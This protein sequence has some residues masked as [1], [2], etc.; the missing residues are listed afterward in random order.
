MACRLFDAKPL[1]K[2]IVAYCQRQWYF[3]QNTKHFIH[4]N[5]SEEIV[6]ELAA[7]LSEG[8]GGGGG[9]G[10]GEIIRG[11]DDPSCS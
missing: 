1:S 11:E 8:G 6:C 2:P 3:N 10:G 9:G 7:I 4:E 5:V